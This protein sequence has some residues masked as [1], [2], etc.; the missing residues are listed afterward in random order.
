MLSPAKPEKYFN[1]LKSATFFGTEMCT[2]QSSLNTIY[3]LETSFI[4]EICYF[5]YI[6]YTLQSS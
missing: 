3:T 5:Y 4:P 1:F 2:L 6:G